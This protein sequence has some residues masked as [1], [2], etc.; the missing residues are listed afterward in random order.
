M[1]EEIITEAKI[2]ESNELLLVLQSGGKPEYSNIYREGVGVYWNNDLK[3]F[4]SS[5]RK[6]WSYPKWFSHIV[7]TTKGCNIH[8][9]ISPTINWHNLSKKDQQEVLSSNAI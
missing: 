1:S 4:V 8:L 7:S 9:V 5:E 3:G 2:L 6:D